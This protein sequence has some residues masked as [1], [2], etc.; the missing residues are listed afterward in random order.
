MALRLYNELSNDSRRSDTHNRSRSGITRVDN[1]SDQSPATMSTGRAVATHAGASGRDRSRWAVKLWWAMAITAASWWLIANVASAQQYETF[2]LDPAYEAFKDPKEASKLERAVLQLKTAKDL[3][4]VE[5]SAPGMSKFYLESYIP[6]KITQRENLPELSSTIEG[7]LKDVDG[8]Q[9]IGS[10][11]TRTLLAGTFI[12]MKKIAEGN[13]MP[14]ARI[15]AINAL[16]R[17]NAKPL[18]LAN[19]RPPLPLSYSYP[20]LYK[21]YTNEKESDGIRAA[22]LHGIHSYVRLA[23]PV[24]KADEKTALVAEMN[25]LLAAEPPKSRD[26]KA[27]AYL[28]RFAVDILNILRAP[29]DASLG[30][31]LISIST[32]EDNPDLIALYS[33]AKLGSFQTGLQGK[34]E[35]PSAVTKQW[36]VRAFNALQSE[37]DR[38]EAQTR[39]RPAQSQP[40]NPIDFLRKAKPKK[41]Q[42]IAATRRSRTSSDMGMGM[43][44]GMGMDA[45]YSPDM[46]MDMEMGME[47]GMGMGMGMEMDMGMGMEMGYGMQMMANPQPPEVNL[48]RRKID[49]VLQQ[50]LQG[51]TGSAKGTPEEKPAGLLAAVPENARPE[52]QAWVDSILQVSEA[53]NDEKLDT[54]ELWL[55]ALELQRPAL[56]DLAGIEV[57]RIEEDDTIE[58]NSL[59][60]FPGMGMRRADDEDELPGGGGLPGGGLPGAP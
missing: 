56:G 17:L 10:A 45:G 41:P 46:D 16:S 27:H 29:N 37:L 54:L 49:F 31:Q 40:P 60:M 21:L 57:E 22:A 33:A 43:G 8:A 58:D 4:K 39:P 18:D 2:K 25:K 7:L 50:L 24:M 23:F 55:E 9:R 51:A 20:I 48:S 42:A 52:V 14:A 12:G 15:N 26:A 1:R 6:W 36:S 44:R 34:V 13:Y 35:D 30:T 47:M 38:F 59:P 3:S 28:Q 32:A 11:G 53:L 19:G 5:A